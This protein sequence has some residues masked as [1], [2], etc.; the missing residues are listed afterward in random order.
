MLD[1]FCRK[2]ALSINGGG[3]AANKT[4]EAVDKKASLV[5]SKGDQ[6]VVVGDVDKASLLSNSEVSFTLNEDFGG[7]H[8]K[9]DQQ[10]KNSEKDLSKKTEVSRTV[11]F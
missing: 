6:L 3:V 7:F 4:P 2:V 11:I 1:F 5:L 10:N 8:G 9:N